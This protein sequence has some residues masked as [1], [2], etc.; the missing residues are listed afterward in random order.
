MSRLSVGRQARAGV[1]H[2]SRRPE[3]R[4][5][6]SP[7]DVAGGGTPPARR[8]EG[9]LV[10]RS[11]MRRIRG[12]KVA[13]LLA[14]ALTLIGAFTLA[15]PVQA[16]SKAPPPR[17]QGPCDIYAAAGDPCVAAHSTTRAM[18]ASY[19]GPLY[20]VKRLSDNALKNIGVVQPVASPF[21]DSGGYADAAAQDAFCA[22]T[23]CWITKVYDQSPNHNDLTQAPRGGF[24]GPAMG[25]VN[26]LPIADMA[27]ITISGHKAYGVFIEP[28]M[29]LRNN[30]TRGTAVDDQPE[31][32][33]GSST[34]STSTT[35]AA[36]TTA[37]PRS[38]AATTATA[39]WR[40]PTTATLPPGITGLRPA[41]GS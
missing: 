1:S 15:V 8:T 32:S 13:A 6:W 18:Y 31:G 11:R 39:R 40:P 20:Q 30:D 34:A 12:G 22:N 14:F 26:N 17:P 21:P 24:S 10:R 41:R 5:S 35:A 25:G 23:T 19:N 3:V 38:T 16:D 36:S 29:G 27:P 7:K 4:R 9:S 28:G 33:T 2:L 37:T